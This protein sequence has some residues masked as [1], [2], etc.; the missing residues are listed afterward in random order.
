MHSQLGT[1]RVLWKS[2]SFSKASVKICKHS[3][4]FQSPNRG[5]SKK[6]LHCRLQRK[7]APLTAVTNLLYTWD[8]VSFTP[9]CLLVR[10]R[11]LGVRY[12][13]R[14]KLGHNAD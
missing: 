8:G 5:A 3:L 6:Q 4:L 13:K 2:I 11:A 14:E 1:K 12:R 9:R 7:V 10:K